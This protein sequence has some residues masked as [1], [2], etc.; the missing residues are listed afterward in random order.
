[1]ADR[2][3]LSERPADPELAR[4]RLRLLIRLVGV[5]SAGFLLGEDSRAVRRLLCVPA[6]PR[7]AARLVWL[8]LRMLTEPERP[9]SV[10]E[11]ATLGRLVVDRSKRRPA[12]RR[13]DQ[14]FDQGDGI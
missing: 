13:K 3:L 7:R 1:M 10:I 4:T 2:H 9:A 6:M 14:T 8:L 5:D 12:V 11:I